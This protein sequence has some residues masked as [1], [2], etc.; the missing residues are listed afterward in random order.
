M[1]KLYK[2]A[3]QASEYLGIDDVSS[4]HDYMQI[5]FNMNSN[6]L[7]AINRSFNKAKEKGWDYTYW[8]FDIH[9]T[10]IVPNYTPNNIP[11]EFYPYAKE[12]LQLISKRKDIKM[13]LYT[14][15][16]PHEVEQYDKLFKDNNIDFDFLEADNPEVANNALGF[17]DYKP[18]F[19]VLF[20]DKAGFTPNQWKY[21]H[22]YLI[23]NPEK[24][25]KELV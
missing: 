6:V 1:D 19:N 9:E 20:E 18:Y 22:Q 2:L 16:H 5:A 7:D 23:D 17:Y 15:S 25:E 12:A 14:C 10:I 8:F 13:H 21:V 4:L 3:M 24:N 11:T